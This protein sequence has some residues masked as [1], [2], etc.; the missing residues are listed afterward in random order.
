[1]RNRIDDEVAQMDTKYNKLG[2]RK[3][4]QLHEAIK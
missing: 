1:M 2:R 3:S 4:R